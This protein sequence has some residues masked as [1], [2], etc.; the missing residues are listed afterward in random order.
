MQRA[1]PVLCGDVESNRKEWTTVTDPE[2]EREMLHSDADG[3]SGGTIDEARCR[4]GGGA[5]P[6]LPPN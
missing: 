3:G 4:G 6:S 2:R 1:V 5:N